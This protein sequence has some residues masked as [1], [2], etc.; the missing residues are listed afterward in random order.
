MKNILQ[1]A[2]LVLLV[3]S[4]I[5][6][7]VKSRGNKFTEL[8]MVSILK[9]FHIKGWRQHL[10]LLGNPNFCFLNKSYYLLMVAFGIAVKN[11]L[12]HLKITLPIGL[13]K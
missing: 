7:S 13:K 2:L 12:D 9:K 3:R 5:M 11:A 4:Y 6:S 1:S 10:L 8:A